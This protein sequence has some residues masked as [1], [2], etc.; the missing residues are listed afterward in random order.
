MFDFTGSKNSYEAFA[1]IVSGFA[2]EL[3]TTELTTEGFSV[4]PEKKNGP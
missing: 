2:K 3:Y 4:V 1:G